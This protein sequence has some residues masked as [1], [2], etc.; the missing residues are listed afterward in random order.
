MKL[1]IDVELTPDADP[2]RAAA[3]IFDH[4]CAGGDQLDDAGVESFDG[5]D[6]EP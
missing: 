6:I 4:L 1:T 5:W 2:E 3:V